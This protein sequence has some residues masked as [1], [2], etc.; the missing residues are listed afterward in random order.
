MILE[1]G[2]ETKGNGLQRMQFILF[3]SKLTCDEYHE[4]NKYGWFSFFLMS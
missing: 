3:I 1:G 4:C 2:G